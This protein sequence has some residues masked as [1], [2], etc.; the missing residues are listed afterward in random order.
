MFVG[1]YG[2]RR[3]KTL[4]ISFVTS[5]ILVFI[6]KKFIFSSHSDHVNIRKQVSK[7]NISKSN[8]TLKQR[9]LAPLLQS[10]EDKST[11]FLSSFKFT[12]S[13]Y[14]DLSSKLPLIIPIIVL[15]K[16]SNIEI[17][18]AIRRTW[19]TDRLYANTT[20]QYKV[21]FLVGID[22]SLL[23]RIQ[24]E[25]ILFD[26]VI[27]VSVSDLSSF[28]AYKEFSAMLWVRKYLPNAPYYIKSEDDIIMNINAVI[29]K[30]LPTIEPYMKKSLIVGW[31]AREH[32]VDRGS[33]QKF[34]NAAIPPLTIDL[35]YAMNSLYIITSEACDHMLDFMNKVNNIMYPGDPFITGI[36]REAAHIEIKNL[37]KST[38][39]FRYE[40]GNGACNE[41]FETNPKL[42]F[43]TTISSSLSSKS[44]TTH[45]VSEYFEVWN[46]L[47]NQNQIL[48]NNIKQ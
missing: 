6:V 4:F 36:L 11:D 13:P 30:L 38:E 41:A 14:L 16:A 8:E 25:Q 15:S 17:R 21:L 7:K 40:T 3:L 29:N 37:A 18:D 34:I 27:Q 45:S 19:G 2:R 46:T 24:S 32:P 5:L 44:S 39:Y 33:Y 47:L 26:D 43:C 10:A 22:D 23:K 9:T 1:Y 20:I 12:N 28:V 48:I 31:F 35:N 42:L